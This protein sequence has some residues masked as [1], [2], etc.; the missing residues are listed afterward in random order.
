MRDRQLAPF[1]LEKL[2]A[3]ATPREAYF[4]LWRFLRRRFLRLC[5][6]ILWRF[7]FLPQGMMLGG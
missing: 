5:V 2:P 4:F 1:P 6:A 3:A 7:L